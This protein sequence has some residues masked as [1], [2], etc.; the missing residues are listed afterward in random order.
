VRNDDI[1]SP[2]EALLHW[3]SLAPRKMPDQ[4]RA[5]RGA[6]ACTRCRTKMQ[7][8]SSLERGRF[9]GVRAE[10]EALRPPPAQWEDHGHAP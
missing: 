8:E 7:A 5:G 10:P 3:F 1:A 4:A 6:N 9:R 2:G